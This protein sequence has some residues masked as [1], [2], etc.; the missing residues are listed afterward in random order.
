MRN[1]PDTGDSAL[2]SLDPRPPATYDGPIRDA[3]GDAP[4][5]TLEQ[6]GHTPLTWDHLVPYERDQGGYWL[7]HPGCDVYGNG[8]IWVRVTPPADKE[9]TT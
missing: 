5:P 3:D 2:I 4:A 9:G 7:Y 1:R 6:L 8:K